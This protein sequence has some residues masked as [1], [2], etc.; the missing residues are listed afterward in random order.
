MAAL[1]G[2]IIAATLEVFAEVGYD[3]LAVREVARR[4]KPIVAFNPMRERGLERFQSPK[5][6]GE[7]LTGG[8]TD[9]VSH[10]FQPRIGSDYLVLQGLMKR[11]LEL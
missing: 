10:Y 9:L 2:A 3:K 6:P 11:L 8:A 1:E 5:H 4:G 7:M